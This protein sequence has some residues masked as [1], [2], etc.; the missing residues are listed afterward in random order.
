MD[1][2]LLIILILVGIWYWWDTQ[3]SNEIALF[4]CKKKC[5]VSGLQLLDA[6]VTRQ[7]SWLRRGSNS[8]V[9]I[10]RLYSFEYSDDQSINYGQRQQGYI[11]LIGK[12]VVET[13][14]PHKKLT[15]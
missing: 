5:E 9:Q 6:T 11:V 13:N 12:Q 2:L 1:D 15:T 4:V 3:Q 7:R 10:C 8:S 14:L